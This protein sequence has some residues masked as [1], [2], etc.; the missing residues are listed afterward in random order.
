MTEGGG[1][2]TSPSIGSDR[3]E[4]AFVSYSCSSETVELTLL[5]EHRVIANR[6]SMIPEETPLSQSFKR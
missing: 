2:Y 5:T 4:L 3:G 6:L 1:I